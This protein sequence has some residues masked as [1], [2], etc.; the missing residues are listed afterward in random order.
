M[1]ME[2]GGRSDVTIHTCGLGG[3]SRRRVL[4]SLSGMNDFVYTISPESEAHLS[5]PKNEFLCWT[6]PK[7]LPIY[8]THSLSVIFGRVGGGAQADYSPNLSQCAH[9][10]GV[11]KAERQSKVRS[12]LY[13]C[14]VSRANGCRTGQKVKMPQFWDTPETPPPS[15]MLYVPP[16]PHPPPEMPKTLF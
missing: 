5:P 6:H 15:K 11:P 9:L 4:P 8:P 16:P 12:V 10:R 14:S 13:S 3:F 2:G 7:R 1:Q